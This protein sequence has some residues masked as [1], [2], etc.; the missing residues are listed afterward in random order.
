[1]F[2]VNIFFKMLVRGGIA[3]IEFVLNKYSEKLY[4]RFIDVIPCEG[5]HAVR[6]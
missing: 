4:F 1:M 6:L 2:L 3:R 5:E